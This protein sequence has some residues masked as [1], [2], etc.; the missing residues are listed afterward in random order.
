MTCCRH[1]IEHQRILDQHLAMI[2]RLAKIID[3]NTKT[4][5]ILVRK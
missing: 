5:G 3:N 4:L 2:E 1:C